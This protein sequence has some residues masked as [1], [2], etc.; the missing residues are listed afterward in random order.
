[1]STDIIFNSLDNVDLNIKHV[2]YLLCIVTVHGKVATETVIDIFNVSRA[3]FLSSLNGAS[4]KID[5]AK[6]LSLMF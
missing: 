5:T 4:N 3:C 2:M 1:M 6:A